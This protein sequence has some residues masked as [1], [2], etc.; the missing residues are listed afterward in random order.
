M[1]KLDISLYNGKIVTNKKGIKIDS[2]ILICIILMFLRK[3]IDKK[4]SRNG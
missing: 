3:V 2:L 1:V 4:R